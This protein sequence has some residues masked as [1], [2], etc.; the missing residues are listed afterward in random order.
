[1]FPP[2]IHL[3]QKIL[4]VVPHFVEF[5]PPIV[6][7]LDAL[8]EQKVLRILLLALDELVREVEHLGVVFLVGG[9]VLLDSLVVRQQ[10]LSFGQIAGNVFGGNGNLKENERFELL[11]EWMDGWING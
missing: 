10:L 5:P 3:R 9:D 11:D 6:E 4:S 1:M 8:S 2:L 7:S